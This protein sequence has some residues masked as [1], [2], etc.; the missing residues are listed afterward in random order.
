LFGCERFE[1]AAAPLDHKRRHSRHG[2]C[3]SAA[4]T[5]TF[6]S[7]TILIQLAA[8]QLGADVAHR[9]FDHFGS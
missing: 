9:S 1:E 6:V 4:L 3:L 7:R 8:R 2:F 5:R